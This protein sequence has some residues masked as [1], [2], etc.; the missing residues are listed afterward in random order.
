MSSTNRTVLPFL[1]DE[2]ISFTYNRKR[3]GPKIEPC[4]TPNAQLAKNWKYKYVISFR[5]SMIFLLFESDVLRYEV[6]QSRAIPR[7]PYEGNFGE[8]DVMVNNVRSFRE[9]QGIFQWVLHFGLL[10]KQHL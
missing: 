8:Q 4:G 5:A 9:I 10:M 3:T 6:I 2:G 7:I 1:I